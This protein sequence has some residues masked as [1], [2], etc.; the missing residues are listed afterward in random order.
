VNIDAVYEGLAAAVRAAM[1]DVSATDY[2]PDS[3]T[4]PAFFPGE[5][6]LDPNQTF[7]G[8]VDVDITCRLLVSRADDRSGRKALMPYLGDGPRSIDRALRVDPTLGG[9][10]D[11]LNVRRIQGYRLYEHAGPTRYL[12]AEIV[13]RVIGDPTEE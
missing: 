3:V 7:G 4:V 10:C 12:G 2:V 8:M 13:V 1:P 6:T 9:A 5:F 11:D